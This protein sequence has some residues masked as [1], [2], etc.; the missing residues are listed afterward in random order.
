MP[1]MGEGARRRR[2][3]QGAKADR[4]Q[5]ELARLDPELARWADDFVFGEV[6]GREGLSF[7]E[8]MLVA[9]SQ[10]AATGRTQQLRNYLFG[11]VQAG[12]DPRKIQE[13]L[14]MLTVYTGFPNA[15]A[16]LATWA[17]VSESAGRQGLGEA[18]EKPPE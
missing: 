18:G 12:V 11:A 2:R 9:I 17:E 6:W 7:E 5:V 8:R 14:V 10:L 4:L 16:A 13:T 3:A 1:P 15:I